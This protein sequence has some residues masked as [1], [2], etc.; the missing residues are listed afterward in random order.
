M[1]M[2]T[3]RT[4]FLILVLGLFMP[5]CFLVE[6]SRIHPVSQ[7]TLETNN[8]YAI[9]WNRTDVSMTHMVGAPDMIFVLGQDNKKLVSNGDIFSFDS[10]TG[11]DVWKTSA[12]SA[13]SG[14]VIATNE[15]VYYGT[16]G[17]AWVEAYDIEN[18]KLLWK[19]GLPWAHS[20]TDLYYAENK[21]FVYTA[22]SEFFILSKDG[23]ILGNEFSSY[24]VYLEIDNVRYMGDGSAIWAVD[25]DSAIE[26]WRF[27]AGLYVDDPVFDNGTIFIAT[28]D[29]IYSIDQATEAENWK[30]SGD[31]LSNLYIAN[32]KIYFV[33]E[34]GY[35]V[36]LDKS[37]GDE[38][39]KVKFSPEFDMSVPR[40]G[41]FFIAGDPEN[42]VI[43][44]SFANSSQ[45]MGIKILDP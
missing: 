35:L 15:R 23:G 5:A 33:S 34:D 43:A 18:G 2:K 7:Y 8:E 45:I 31:V 4:G 25:V 1:T 29:E 38:I 10:L 32:D 37:T 40:S 16:V 19:T 6:A 17:L 20:V 28:W 12:G 24:F 9:I 27:E 42:N 30:A 22:D 13:G 44:V 14:T 11:E 21:I 26:L 41:S 3:T 39:S 36:A